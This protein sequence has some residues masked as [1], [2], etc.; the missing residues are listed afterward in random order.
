MA[1]AVLSF[2][3]M[4]GDVKKTEE[5]GELYHESKPAVYEVI[6]IVHGKPLFPKEH[7]ERLEGS[8]ASIGQKTPLTYEEF[9]EN[10]RKLAEA[11]GVEDYNCRLVITNFAD[12]GAAAA[13]NAGEAAGP[14]IYLFMIPTHYPTEEMYDR[15]VKVDLLHAVR[16]NPHSKIWNQELRTAADNMIKERGLFEVLLLNEKDQVTEGS[17]SNIF[18]IFD[19]EAFTTPSEAVLLGVTRTKVIEACEKA[20]IKVN[21]TYTTEEEIG[22]YEAAFVCG[23][24]P[25]VLPIA[26]I[27][28]TPMD[29]KQKL[30]RKIMA[31]YDEICEE[32]LG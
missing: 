18:F 13:D 27:G 22:D 6:R 11:N 24:S 3:F 5:F 17:R 26:A 1:E 20:G 12:G 25:K 2:F 7:Y 4:N 14:D 9:C 28:S 21:E 19:N 31:L 30:L 16:N 8:M 23:T 10:V 29:T 15:G 32:S